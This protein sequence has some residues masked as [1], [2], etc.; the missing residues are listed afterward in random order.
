MATIIKDFLYARPGLGVAHA[1]FHLIVQILCK[2]D[3]L[4]SLIYT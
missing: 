3:T 1:L 4:I 2:I